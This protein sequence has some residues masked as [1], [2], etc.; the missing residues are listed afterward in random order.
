M[1][2]IMPSNNKNKIN[3]KINVSDTWKE[4]HYHLNINLCL[5]YEIVF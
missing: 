5:I 1:F 3:V 2:I 4:N